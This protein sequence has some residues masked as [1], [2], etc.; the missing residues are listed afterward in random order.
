[1]KDDIY[2][3]VYIEYEPIGVQCRLDFDFFKN[4]TYS[5]VN[6]TSDGTIYTSNWINEVLVK[7][8]SKEDMVLLT[9][10]YPDIKFVEVSSKYFS[11]SLVRYLNSVT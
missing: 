7:N 5:Q 4:Y 2:Y 10:R 8:L 9:L 6:R 11:Y 1:M 3:F